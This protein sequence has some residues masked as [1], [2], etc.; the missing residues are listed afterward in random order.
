MSLSKLS[1]A[2]LKALPEHER[3][4]RMTRM[5]RALLDQPIDASFPSVRMISKI[6]SAEVIRKLEY[7]EQM[8]EDFCVY[9]I[10]IFFVMY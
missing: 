3:P 10:I 9:V 1:F 4:K 5:R 8:Y 2:E 6:L 7:V